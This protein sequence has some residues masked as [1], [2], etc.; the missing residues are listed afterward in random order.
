MALKAFDIEGARLLAVDDPKI[1]AAMRAVGYVWRE[2]PE[3]PKKTAIVV[4]N[5]NLIRTQL[6]RLSVRARKKRKEHHVRRRR[7]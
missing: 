7:K 6:T 5:L 3:S 2:V 4:E 1:V